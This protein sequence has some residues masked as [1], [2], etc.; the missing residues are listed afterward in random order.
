MLRQVLYVGIAVVL[1]SVGCSASNSGM[2]SDMDVSTQGIWNKVSGYIALWTSPPVRT[3]ADHS[4]DGPLMGNGDMGV[5]IGGPAEKLRFYLSKNDFWRLKSKAG[6][7]SPKVFGYLDITCESLKGADYRIE[8]SIV[9]GVTTGTFKRDN[10]TVEFK[11]FVAASDNVLIVELATK[12]GDAEV[13]V[14]LAAANGSG[15]DSIKGTDGKIYW[16]V[17]KFEKDVDIP[18]EA[19]AAM[20]IIGSD[21]TTLKLVPEKNV[22]VIIT[23]RSRFKHDNPLSQAKKSVS[24]ITP[25]RIREIK[26][27][28]ALW[29]SD[30]WKRSWVDIDNP[31]IERSYY[32]SLYSMAAA[33]RDPKFPPAIF[34]TWVTTDSPAWAGDYHL[35]YNHMAPF[36]AL[37]SANRIEQADPQDTPILDFIDRG[38]WYAENV[39]NTRGVLFPRWHRSAGNRNNISEY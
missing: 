38:R 31:V 32:Q 25:H 30:Y 22:T 19:A 36:Y 24:S 13:K 34:G 15:S 18:S 27:N 5:C 16:A 8:Q 9:D 29:W 3:P 20:K 12:G 26:K 7:S 23:M 2:R 4:V 17:R 28:H 6:Q 35:N 10:I 33:S 14:A 11:S 21:S 1:L 37:Y 39:T